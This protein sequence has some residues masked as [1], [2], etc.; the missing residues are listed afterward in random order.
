[1]SRIPSLADQRRGAWHMQTTASSKSAGAEMAGRS[2]SKP[3]LCGC[4][5]WIK[6]E[7]GIQSEW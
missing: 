2:A 7:V 3:G 4:A 5:S 6:L 1:M